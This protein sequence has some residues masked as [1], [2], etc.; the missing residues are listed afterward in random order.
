VVADASSTAQI[1]LLKQ[2]IRE[3]LLQQQ[4]L[5]VTIEI[6]YR[7]EHCQFIAP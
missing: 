5:H 2:K 6:E 4:I 3:Y 1:S 7:S